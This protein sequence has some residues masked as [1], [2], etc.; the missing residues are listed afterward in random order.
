MYV[1]EMEGGYLVRVVAGEELMESLRTLMRERDIGSGAV[2]GLGAVG[3]ARLGAYE[4]STKD[5][6]DR[7]FEGDLE[8]VGLT[9]T[10]SWYEGEPFAHVHLVLTDTDFQTVGGHCFEARV[11]AT[12]ELFVRVWDERVERQLDPDIGL[13]LMDLPLLSEA[14]PED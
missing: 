7:E 8:V 11:S 4:A 13:H 12:I 2:T 5:Y 9:G 1:K 14:E 3:W 6:V 10:M